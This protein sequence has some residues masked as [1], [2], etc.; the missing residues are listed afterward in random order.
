MTLSQK[1]IQKRQN[2]NV[3]KLYEYLNILL[4][5]HESDVL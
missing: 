4:L 1:V 2:L 5:Y 3:K